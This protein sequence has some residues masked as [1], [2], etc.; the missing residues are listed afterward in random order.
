MPGE[1]LVNTGAPPIQWPTLGQAERRVLEIQTKLHQWASTD[2]HRRFDD[3]FNLVCD[4]AFLLVGWERVRGNR[5][6]RTAGVDKVTAVHVQVLG[7]EEFLA[8]LRAS[9]KAGTFHPLPVR[10]RMIPKPG[11]A[12]KRRLGIPTIA[13][14]V[15]QA[16]L[17]LVLEP[18]FEADFKPCSYGFR[19]RRRP[20]DAAEIH[21][22][23]TNSY[24]WVGVAPFR[25]TPDDDCV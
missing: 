25:R 2:R 1:S 10:E 14:R 16:S 8:G 12:K 6:A 19:P 17:K 13:D 22:F 5:G 18:I 20:H 9:L 3:V 11:T 23:A 24:E 21:M 4:P 15:V 7:G